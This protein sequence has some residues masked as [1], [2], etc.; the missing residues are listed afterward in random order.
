[1]TTEFQ[2]AYIVPTLHE[3]L[4]GGAIQISRVPAIREILGPMHYEDDVSRKEQSRIRNRSS[5]SEGG[6]SAK[7][8]IAL[9]K[10]YLT[11]VVNRIA[12][13]L[14]KGSLEVAQSDLYDD[15]HDT[16]AVTR[17]DYKGHHTNPK[18][19]VWRDRLVDDENIYDSVTVDGVTYRV[20]FLFSTCGGVSLQ[21]N[22]RARLVTL[23]WLNQTEKTGRKSVPLLHRLSISTEIVGGV[24]ASH[25]P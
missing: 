11:P 9:G 5:K 17:R 19:I 8:T 7:K 1:M 20:G 4:Y 15:D 24:C 14:F 22:T 12:K 23:S 25:I 21:R 2:L 18:K 10:T 3:L 6:P 16:V 13:N